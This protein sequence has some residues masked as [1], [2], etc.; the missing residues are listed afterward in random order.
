LIGLL[1]SFSLNDS[2]TQ[3]CCKMYKPTICLSLLVKI[4][5][6]PAVVMGTNVCNSLSVLFPLLE[7]LWEGILL[8]G[9]SEPSSVTST[10]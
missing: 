2:V 4:M 7:S 5:D 8:G 9:L 1:G 3:V 6:N 10:D